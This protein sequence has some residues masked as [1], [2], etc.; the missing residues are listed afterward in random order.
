MTAVIQPR[1]DNDRRPTRNKIRRGIAAAVGLIAM[2]ATLTVSAAAAQA[3]SG[4]RSAPYSARFGLSDPFMAFD[5][6]EVASAPY[7][8]TYRTTTQ[9]RDIQVKNTGNGR[10]DGAPF[11]ACVVFSGR[12][13]CAN[14]WTYVPPGQWRNLATNVKDGTRFNVWISVNLGRYYGAQAVGDW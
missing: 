9:C 3:A 5:G 13:T 12:A 14:G 6:V 1:S 11:H 4:C 10:S 7:G 8:G 2:A